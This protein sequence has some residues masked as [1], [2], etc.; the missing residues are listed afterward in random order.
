MSFWDYLE[1]SQAELVRQSI[2]HL[3][4]V[5]VAMAVAIAIGVPV[6]I[7][8]AR[9]PRASRVALGFANIMQTV[10]ALALFGLL[11][12]LPL[13]GGTDAR[14]AIIALMLYALLPIIRNTVTG[15]RG[16]DPAV[17][18]AASAMG[19]TRRQLLY[20]VELPLALPVIVAGV[21]IAAVISVGTATIAA[22]AGAEGLGVFIFR[23]LETFNNHALL[24]GAIPAAL[25]A[26]ILDACLGLAERRLAVPGST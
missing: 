19:M 21:R 25:L 16:V 22:A 3:Y 11:I 15:L 18:D 2:R 7:A 20:R 6:G 23:G 14:P 1:A 4:L 26:L 24:L 5:G 9:R 17:R 8:V 13:I 12:P 10:P